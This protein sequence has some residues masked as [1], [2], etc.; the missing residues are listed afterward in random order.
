MQK[1]LIRLYTLVLASFFLYHCSSKELTPSLIPADVSTVVVLDM[2]RMSSKAIEWKDMFSTEFLKNI[3]GNGNKADLMG[4]VLNGGFDYQKTAYL[5]AKAGNT[6]EE[7]YMALAFSLKDDKQFEKTLLEDNPALDIK[8]DGNHKYASLYTGV[9]V[10]WQK[11]KA[12]VVIAPEFDTKALRKTANNILKTKNSNA[13]ETKNQTFRNALKEDADVITWIDYSQFPKTVT[14]QLQNLNI[15]LP[16]Q[17]LPMMKVIEQVTLLTNFEQ[18][19]VKTRMK[20]YANPESI[21]VYQQLIKGAVDAQVAKD[22]PIEHPSML[23]GVG[24]GT[25]GI[26]ELLGHS[27]MVEGM[28]MLLS[29][30]GTSVKE[31]LGMYTGDLV[32]AVG[33]VKLSNDLNEQEIVIGIGTHDSQKVLKLITDF[34][35]FLKIKNKKDHYIIDLYDYELGEWFMVVKDKNVYLTT[36]PTLKDALLS[37]QTKLNSET[38]GLF[39]GKVAVGEVDYG[40]FLKNLPEFTPNTHEARQKL[41]NT[42]DKFQFSAKPL[43]NNIW[44][45]ESTLKMKDKS[46][47]SLA[48]LFQMIREM[49]KVVE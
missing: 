4:K 39:S 34:D 2:K 19:E 8:K 43:A 36:S 42:I 31:I 32:L 44:E 22:I 33:N 15:D 6:I 13:L 38:L 48:V 30:S 47:N 25:L 27:K 29:F 5:F 49:P 40:V 26:E 9:L 11:T 14:K 23:M 1:P 18:G 41:T 45:G 46:R 28:K 21:K 10:A 12:L 37:N 7:S 35:G 24:V 20:A 16:S 3:T 17:F